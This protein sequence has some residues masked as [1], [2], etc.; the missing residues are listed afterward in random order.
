MRK[1][2][3]EFYEKANGETPV[4]DFLNAIDIK[5]RSKLLM[6]LKVLEEKEML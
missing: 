3:I 5:V 4:E 1:Y 6:V 2:I